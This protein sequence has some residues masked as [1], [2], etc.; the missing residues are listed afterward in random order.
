MVPKWVN[1]LPIPVAPEL[2]LQRLQDFGTCVYDTF[3]KGIDVVS[4]EVKDDRSA[5][6]RQR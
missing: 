4:G 1:E 3:P 2:V 6:Y 5:T